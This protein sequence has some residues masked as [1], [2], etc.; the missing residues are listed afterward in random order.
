MK[1]IDNYEKNKLNS[2]AINKISFSFEFFPPKNLYDDLSLKN[3]SK[4]FSAY[5]PSFFSITYSPNS[6]D[7]Y[8]TQNLALKIQNYTNIP[9]AAHLTCIDISRIE[10][11]NIIKNYWKNGIKNI[12]ALRGDRPKNNISVSSMYALDLVKLLKKTAD[13]NISVAAYPETHPESTSAK[14]D[15]IFL[16][17]KLDAGADQAITQFFFD[18]DKFLYFRDEC[19]KIGIT[20]PIIPGILPIKNFIQLKKFSNLTNVT[21]PKHI[22]NLFENITLENNY[23][24]KIIGSI[25][26]SQMIEKLYKE[27]INNF[28]FYTLNDVEM[29]NSVCKTI[30]SKISLM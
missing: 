27:G 19:I 14:Q 5:N 16:K 30:N 8:R 13:F 4:I 26:I 28:H 1:N 18:I 6:C 21:I 17:K 3:I 25:L 7:R 10:L 9:T 11:L 24:G 2:V 29:I 12:V 23:S 15:L 22:S 20:K